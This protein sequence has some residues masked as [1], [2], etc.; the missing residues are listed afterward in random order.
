MCVDACTRIYIYMYIYTHTYIHTYIY[1]VGS[2]LLHC[3][4]KKRG[5]RSICSPSLQTDSRLLKMLE[6]N[7]NIVACAPAKKNTGAL[8]GGRAGTIQHL[9]M[10]TVSN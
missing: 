1:N 7:M 6:P 8:Y 9:A 3:S 4:A 10:Q 2:L 5:R